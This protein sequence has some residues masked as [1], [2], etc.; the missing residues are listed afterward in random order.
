MVVMI[1]RGYKALF[2]ILFK[3]DWYKKELLYMK[4]L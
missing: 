4:P 3:D 2:I 1:N